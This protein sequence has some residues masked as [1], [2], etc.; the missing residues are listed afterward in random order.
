M[1]RPAWVFSIL[2]VFSFSALSQSDPEIRTVE[3]FSPINVQRQISDP[4]AA[5]RFCFSFITERISCEKDADL[6]YGNVRLGEDWDWF[7]V[8]GNGS[9]NKL[10]DLGRKSWTD[11][12]EVPVVK[13]YA[14]LKPG[15]QR[16]VVI[17]ASGAQ[18]NASRPRLPDTR[19]A[20]PAS[21]DFDP[22]DRFGN[23]DKSVINPRTEYT[24]TSKKTSI[25]QPY[26]KV[27][28]GNMYVLRVVDETNDFYV[29]F[30]V[31]ELERGK[32]A[33]ISWKRIEAPKGN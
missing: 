24:R 19:R 33:K 1:K 28:E 6:Y 22:L 29:L 16:S 30:R 3:L 21:V 8:A 32:R 5:S 27:F 2:L 12:F 13:P 9:R 26:K 23:L 10:K 20:S 31:D 11:D 25:Y 14:K 7:Q 15:K 18:A 4:F 17:D